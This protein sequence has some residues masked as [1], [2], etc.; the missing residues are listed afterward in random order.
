MENYE[1]KEYQYLY[2][3][4]DLY[5]FMVKA[6]GFSAGQL[7]RLKNNQYVST[8]TIGVL[9]TILECSVEDIMEFRMDKSEGLYPIMETVPK[10]PEEDEA[11][12]DEPE[13][14]EAPF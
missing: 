11:E 4:G 8:H 7:N 6:Y 3:D 12:E 14:S 1:R 2:A 5:N 13:E 10:Q 9:C